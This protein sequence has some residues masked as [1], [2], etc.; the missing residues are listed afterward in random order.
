ME[1]TPLQD[2]SL[3]GNSMVTIVIRE[4]KWNDG[5]NEDDFIPLGYEDI[6]E[7]L[8]NNGADVNF[9]NEDFATPLHL[10]ALKGNLCILIDKSLQMADKA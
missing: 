8:I 2:A 10:A 6:T 5:S 7:L 1:G 9:E 4:W 3:E